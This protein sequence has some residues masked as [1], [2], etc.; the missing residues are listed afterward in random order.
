MCFVETGDLP[1]RGLL[2][3]SLHQNG[4]L[5]HRVP[6][7]IPK[8]H[9]HNICQL[10]RHQE[11]E[12]ATPT[13]MDPLATTPANSEA[14]ECNLTDSIEADSSTDLLSPPSPSHEGSNSCTNSSSSVMRMLSCA[15]CKRQRASVRSCDNNAC[16]RLRVKS[17]NSSLST[18]SLP[19]TKC[20]SKRT[21]TCSVKYYF[22]C[23]RHWSDGVLNSTSSF[24]SNR[25]F[26]DGVT[27]LLFSASQNLQSYNTGDTHSVHSETLSCRSDSAITHGRRF[28]GRVNNLTNNLSYTSGRCTTVPVSPLVR[29]HNVQHQ[30]I[31][32]VSRQTSTSNCDYEENNMSAT[33]TNTSVVTV[34]NGN[35]SS[36]ATGKPCS[37]QVDSDATIS[38]ATPPRIRPYIPHRENNH[39]QPVE[40]GSQERQENENNTNIENGQLL[41]R[42]AINSDPKEKKVVNNDRD[43][44]DSK[45]GKSSREMWEVKSSTPYH[46]E[47]ITKGMSLEGRAD[48]RRK[49]IKILPLL[50]R[51]GNSIDEMD[52]QAV[53]ELFMQ[54]E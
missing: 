7:L 22:Q 25:G 45:K 20:C 30:E 10:H 11:A 26:G 40:T 48:S 33:S 31:T 13:A 17:T 9:S 35:E 8:S 15:F 34:Y 44:N 18:S 21:C 6:C 2:K 52:P 37:S 36:N 29:R 50:L 3:D 51:S 46:R 53:M 12:L 23:R 42:L 38:P 49:G 28:A 47:R 27:P 19:L 54:N 24:Q 43:R 16:E 4:V 14:K 41:Q 39:V 5:C 1:N 32:A